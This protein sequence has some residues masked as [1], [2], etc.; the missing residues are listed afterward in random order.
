MLFDQPGQQV[1]VVQFSVVITKTV[2][3]RADVNH[4]HIKR[5]PGPGLELVIRKLLGQQAVGALFNLAK[6]AVDT[7]CV[8][9]EYLQLLRGQR[10]QLSGNGLWRILPANTL[11]EGQVVAP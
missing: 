10:S 3:H 5:R 4:R 7:L 1:L 9:L 2:D 6:M 11:I 8:A